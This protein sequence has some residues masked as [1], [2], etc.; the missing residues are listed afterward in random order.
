LKECSQCTRK[1]LIIYEYR[2]KRYCHS[3]LRPIMEI[4]DELDGE[5]P[6][7]DAK[8]FFPYFDE[9]TRQVA[10]DWNMV[11]MLIRV[12]REDAGYAYLKCGFI[13][14]PQDEFRFS[15]REKRQWGEACHEYRTWKETSEKS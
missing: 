14:S 15:K 1:D 13:L 12:G 3:C 6:N 7:P 4:V 2:G 8:L 5:P 10:V 11:D 9:E